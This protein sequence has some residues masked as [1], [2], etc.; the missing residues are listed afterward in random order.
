[1]VCSAT[2]TDG[3]T[4]DIPNITAVNQQRMLNMNR[5]KR[6]IVAYNYDRPDLKTVDGFL[7]HL[8]VLINQDR[9][10]TLK[11][12]RYSPDYALT[13]PDNRFTLGEFNINGV[14]TYSNGATFIVKEVSPIEET[15]M[16][17]SKTTFKAGNRDEDKLLSSAYQEST[18][19]TFSLKFGEKITV[20]AG[21]KIEGLASFET[22]GELNSEQTWTTAKTYT[23]TAPSQ[24]ISI[25]ANHKKDVIFSLYRGHS[26]T[27]GFL[28]AKIENL[29]INTFFTRLPYSIDNYFARFLSLPDLIA[30]VKNNGHRN[31]FNSN[32]MISQTGN[33]L[34]LNI[35]CELRSESSR[36][37]VNIGDETPL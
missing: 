10:S 16:H 25:R 2:E 19:E 37:E 7:K 36:L 35:P 3:L 22:T 13:L 34:Y 18:T 17:S 8:V 27:K 24:F 9:I 31:L 30:E 23:I 32:S 14:A 15:L 26:L 12:N 20:K 28:R 5:N 11:S 1:M 29:K 21:F 33:D 4:T 6:H